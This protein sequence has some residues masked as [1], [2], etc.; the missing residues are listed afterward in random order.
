MKEFNYVIKDEIGMH[1]RPAG[2][3]VKYVTELT[4]KVTVSK[5]EKTVEA[6]RLFG[7]MGLAIKCAD[8]IT[9]KVEGEN[10]ESETLALEEFCAKNF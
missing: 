5:G 6:N 7:I 9:F 3:L 10:E 1:A 4:S 2:E 8:T